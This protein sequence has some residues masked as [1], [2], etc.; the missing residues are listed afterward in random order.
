[1][2]TGES[3]EGLL[4]VADETCIPIEERRE[5]RFAM[6]TGRRSAPSSRSTTS[7]ARKA[8]ES[9]REALLQAEREARERADGANRLKDEFLATISHELRTPATGVL[10]WARLLRGGRL[11]AEQTRQALEALERGAQ[12]QARLLDD[13]LDMSRIIRG[14]LRIELAPVD[15]RD[16]LAGAVET[17]TPAMHAKRIAVRERRSGGLPLV[18]AIP[19]GCVRCSGTCCRTRSSSASRAGQSASPG[20]RRPTTSS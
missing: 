8:S 7:A 9:E 2:P 4:L 10:G 19:I 5:R 16:V 17:V 11:D 13:L 6:P 12:A 14:T 15:V 1:M 3:R 18:R 20:A